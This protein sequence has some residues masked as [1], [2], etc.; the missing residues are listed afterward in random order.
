M[1]YEVALKGAYRKKRYVLGYV[2]MEKKPDI[3]TALNA[4]GWHYYDTRACDH[5]TYMDKNENLIVDY[6]VSIRKAVFK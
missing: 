5:K 1:L 6:Q 3:E 4:I 2:D